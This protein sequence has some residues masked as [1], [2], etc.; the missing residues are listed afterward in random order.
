MLIAVYSRKSKWSERGDSVE[1]QVQMCTEYIRSSINGGNQAQIRVYEDEGFSGKNTKRPQ[2]QQMMNDMRSL[3]FDYLV[4]YRLD[5]LGRNLADLVWLIEKLNRCRTEFISIREKFDTAAPAGKAMLYFSGV[6]AQMEREQIAERV[7]DNMY[8]LARSGRWL[9]GR[10]PAGFGV[11]EERSV[12]PDGKVKKWFRLCAIDAELSDIRL[13]FS[14][15]EQSASLTE[16][17]DWCGLCGITGR[18]GR[19]Y[20]ARAVREILGNPVYCRA[21]RQA[22]DYFY[23]K[24]CRMCTDREKADGTF[25]FT[26]YART[27]C[28]E[29]KGR[30]NPACQWIIAAG[31]HEGV[32]PGKTFVKIQRM[33]ERNR[34]GGKRDARSTQSLLSGLF[35]CGCGGRM[36]PK[37]YGVRQTEPDGTRRFSYRCAIRD[38]TKAAACQSGPVQG[39]SLDRTVCDFLLK[40]TD[41]QF[42]VD[43][44][45]QKARER[46]A[47]DST[48][49]SLQHRQIRKQIRECEER[50]RRLICALEYE[51]R[52]LS[53][54]RETEAQMERLEH[55]KKALSEL[56]VCE[57]KNYAVK[58]LG[59]LSFQEL[60]A[61]L[62]DARKREYIKIRLQKAVWEKEEVHLYV[63]ASPEQ[64][65]AVE[66]LS[67][68]V[69]DTSLSRT[70]WDLPQR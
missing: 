58:E 46:A 5:R 57:G 14:H 60:F 26:A 49:L 7:R 69:C 50:K 10:T 11:C 47:E 55:R 45:L 1:N 51:S 56:L 44:L 17:A 4:C 65:C 18:E 9:G 35:F 64:I 61:G 6:L 40:L 38:D 68:S 22:W 43:E 3:H 59:T 66:G 30:K 24:G 13:I 42:S 2:F 62:T 29:Y 23:K 33:L 67:V 70:R 48:N 52:S 19:A 15:Y 36:R 25:G 54:I 63:Y 21:D 41:R 27:G 28:S 34:R 37:Y 32:I 53:F 16:T 20:T 12:M 31:R 8:M 39:N